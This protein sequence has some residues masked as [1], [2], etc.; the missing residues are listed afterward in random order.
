MTGA[1]GGSNMCAGGIGGRAVM[2]GAD[3]GSNMCAGGIGGGPGCC[4]GGSCDGGGCRSTGMGGHGPVGRPGGP[5]DDATLGGGW[6]T[7]MG[8]Q[9]P[10]EPAAC[11]LGA[12]VLLIGGR[13]TGMGGHGPGAPD[14][15]VAPVGNDSGVKGC[16]VKGFVRN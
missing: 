10:A 9:G 15:A 1:D 8:G 2:T 12:G 3:G 11:A 4:G 14:G 6:R 5:D 16:I 7:G 13:N